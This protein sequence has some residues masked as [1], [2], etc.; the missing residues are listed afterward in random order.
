MP[1]FCFYG[2]HIEMT[3]QKNPQR[4]RLLYAVITLGVIVVGIASRKMP[5]LFPA[6]LDKYPGD[7]LWALMVFF[8]LG[9]ALPRCSTGKLGLCALGISFL[10]ELSQLYQAPWINAIR[11]TMAGHLVLGSTFSWG[12]LLAYIVGVAIGVGAEK[13]IRLLRTRTLMPR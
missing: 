9:I 3:A 2:R 10:D 11:A 8:G 6:V 12:D 7:V 13:G 1:F 4:S 5:G